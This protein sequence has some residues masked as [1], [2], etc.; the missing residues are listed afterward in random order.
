MSKMNDREVGWIHNGHK[1]CV[2]TKL[3]PRWVRACLEA[4]LLVDLTNLKEQGEN[5]RDVCTENKLMS[6]VIIS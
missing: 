4:L 3:T 2:D 5:E 1:A 6:S